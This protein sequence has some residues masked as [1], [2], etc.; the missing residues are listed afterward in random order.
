M[1]RLDV[2]PVSVC[3]YTITAAKLTGN[4]TL[5]SIWEIIDATQS[6]T[7][8]LPRFGGACC[9]DASREGVYWGNEG[10]G[11]TGFRS[12]YSFYIL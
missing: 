10:H 2:D 5:Q 7:V 9:K 12:T 3:V 11:A 1:K 6:A 8:L 4:R